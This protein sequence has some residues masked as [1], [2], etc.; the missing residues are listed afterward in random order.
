MPAAFA[1]ISAAF[2]PPSPFHLVGWLALDDQE[3]CAGGRGK[4]TQAVQ[5]IPP[6]Q[7]RV[8]DDAEAELEL[9][10][11]DLPDGLVGKVVEEGRC[12]GR[13]KG[14]LEGESAVSN[15]IFVDERDFQ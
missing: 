12:D 15:V 2:D 5:V 6:R 1:G 9:S 4:E 13:G 3:P 11:S 8:Y 14:L 10:G 7:G